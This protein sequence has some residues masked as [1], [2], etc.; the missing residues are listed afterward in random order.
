MVKRVLVEWVKNA[1]VTC[2]KQVKRYPKGTESLPSLTE[3]YY[4][5]VFEKGNILEMT[6]LSEKNGKVN[7]QLDSDNY[8]F[9]LFK[10]SFIIKKELSSLA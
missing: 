6:I 8:I 1:K 3:S 7:V 2:T 10:N 5:K 9:D 4:D